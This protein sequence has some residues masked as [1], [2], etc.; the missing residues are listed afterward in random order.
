MDDY[1]RHRLGRGARGEPTV[2]ADKTAGDVIGAAIAVHRALGPGML[3]STYEAALTH[4]LSLR[5]IPYERQLPIVIRYR[6]IVAGTYELDL[7][8]DEVLIVELKVASSIADIHIAQTL[9]YL[10]ATGLQLGLIL[11]F[12]QTT[13]R[14][15]IRRVVRT[16][17]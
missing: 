3:E 11:N 10:A 1:R 9:A 16:T 4:E 2:H 5:E 13:L 7:V 8:V 15:G 14:D 6:G 12:G 17:P